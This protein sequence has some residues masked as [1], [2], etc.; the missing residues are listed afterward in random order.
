MNTVGIFVDYIIFCCKITGYL[1]N[2]Q[3]SSAEIEGKKDGF[4]HGKFGAKNKNYYICPPK[5]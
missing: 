1:L 5:T 3:T 4:S 2:I